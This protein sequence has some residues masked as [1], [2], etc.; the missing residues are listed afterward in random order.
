MH[1]ISKLRLNGTKLRYHPLLR[2]DTP[3]DENAVSALPTEVGKAQER[4]RFRLSFTTLLSVSGGEP[5]KLDQSRLL[6]IELQTNLGQPF[7]KCFQESLSVGSVFETHHKVSSAGESH[8]DALSE[9]C[10]NVSAHTAP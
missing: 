10:L 7:P 1:P 5:S 2:R 4:E 3:D 9:P 8:P 6:C